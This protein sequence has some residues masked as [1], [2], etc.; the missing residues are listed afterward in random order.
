MYVSP[1][2]VAT[3]NTNGAT[4]NEINRGTR[5]YQKFPML[6]SLGLQLGGKETV[7]Y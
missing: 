3:E 6:F 7:F 4:E 2:L 5:G 1:L